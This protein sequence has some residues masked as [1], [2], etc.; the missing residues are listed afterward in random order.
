MESLFTDIIPIEREQKESQDAFFKSILIGDGWPRSIKIDKSGLYVWGKKQTDA[1]LA[2]W[3]DGSSKL[4]NPNIA[5]WT[6]N[7]NDNGSGWT[8]TIGGIVFN[9]RLIGWLPYKF[10]IQ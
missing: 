2:I 8:V 4:T 5:W 1:L 7:V 10:L 3:M 9:T 6:F